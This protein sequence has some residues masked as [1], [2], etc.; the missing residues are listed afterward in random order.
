[1]TNYRNDAASPA[2]DLK[3]ITPTF[4]RPVFK[5]DEADDIHINEVMANHPK[6]Y[7]SRLALIIILL[8]AMDMI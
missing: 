1:M 4:P 3:T 8:I 2:I 6:K 5:T 7:S